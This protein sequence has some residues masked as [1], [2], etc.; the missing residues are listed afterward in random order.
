MVAFCFLC[1]PDKK[2]LLALLTIPHLK[3]NY[4]VLSGS[5]QHHQPQEMCHTHSTD[6]YFN[7]IQVLF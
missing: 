3:K 5:L 7:N 6:G 1:Q 4:H 2:T